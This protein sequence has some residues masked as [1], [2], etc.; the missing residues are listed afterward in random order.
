M[1]ELSNKTLKS[2]LK[3]NKERY[4][5]G[6]QE[7]PASQLTDKARELGRDGEHITQSREYGEKAARRKL[8]LGYQ[9]ED[10]EQE[11]HVHRLHRVRR[12]YQPG[13]YELMQCLRDGDACVLCQSRLSVGDGCERA[14]G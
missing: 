6:S 8:N 5:S 9:N 1:D 2:Y 13:C 3:K 12:G 14:P 10:V 11:E 7:G 4:W